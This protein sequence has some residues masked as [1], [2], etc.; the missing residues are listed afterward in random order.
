M[1]AS[2]LTDAG[3]K[4]GLFTSPHI[5]DYRERIRI[6]GLCIPESYVVRFIQSLKKQKLKFDPSFFEVTFGLALHYFE[7]ESC[8]IC[9]IETGLGGRLDSTNI[10]NPLVSVITNISLEHTQLLGETIPE[11]ALEKA[12]IIKPNVPLV[13]RIWS[14]MKGDKRNDVVNIDK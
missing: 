9:V 3:F 5:K 6:N 12:G 11:I 7:E 1:L 13:G 8:D 2:I 10:I 4:V 14:G